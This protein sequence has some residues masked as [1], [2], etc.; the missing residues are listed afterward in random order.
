MKKKI[1]KRPDRMG[2][3]EKE[4]EG[5]GED[6]EKE[7]KREEG[8]IGRDREKEKKEGRSTLSCF[9]RILRKPVK[10]SDW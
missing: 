4:K 7:K 3:K 2:K 1:K 8:G 10:L 5:V 9:L 6:R